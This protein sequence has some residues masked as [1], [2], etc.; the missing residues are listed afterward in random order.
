[1]KLSFNTET[2]FKNKSIYEA[3]KLLHEHGIAA[4]EFWSWHDKDLKH[5]RRLQ[6]ETGME[7]ASIVVTPES[8]VDPSRRSA[9]LDA[10]KGTAEACRELGCRRMVQTVG[11]VVPGRSREEMKAA[12]IEGL[13]ACVPVLEEYEVISA[14]EP[15]NTVIDKELSD[16]YLNT[17]EEAFSIAAH[18]GHPL[19][20]VCYDMYHV[21]IMEGNVLTRLQNNIHLVGHIQAAGVPGR[22]ELYMGELNYDYILDAIKQMDY[23]G[24]VGMEY[25]PVH[26][27][28]YDLQQL[29]SKYYT[30]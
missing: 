30:G 11:S 9:L 28:I 14:I 7:V 13:E 16:I 18:I 24:F 20:K 10:V 22:H 17:S 26:D 15:L 29:H 2:L 12:L 19:V 25:F 4:V 23:D 21:Q 5:I 3:I 8:L 6:Q 27:P 1:M